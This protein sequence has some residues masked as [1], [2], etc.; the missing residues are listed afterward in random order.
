MR[1]LLQQGGTIPAT[2]IDEYGAESEKKHK[3]AF[4]RT[5]NI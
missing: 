5:K 3:L 4:A 1:I 2:T